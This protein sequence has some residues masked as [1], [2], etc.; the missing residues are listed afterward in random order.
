MAEITNINRYGKLPENGLMAVA[1]VPFQPVGS[2]RYEPAT[3]LSKGTLFPNLDMPWKNISNQT[4]PYADTPLGELMAL[5]FALNELGL[6]LD[7]HEDDAEALELFSKYNSLMREGYDKYVKLY[8]PI[9]Q[10]DVSAGGWTWVSDPWP[11]EFSQEK[12]GGK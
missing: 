12:R 6:Y 2:T 1:Y 9:K 8:G 7:T 10:T 3:G 5:S 4:N 11:W